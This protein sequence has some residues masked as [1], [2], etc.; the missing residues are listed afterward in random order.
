MNNKLNNKIFATMNPYYSEAFWNS[1]RGENANTKVL[2]DAMF[3][4]NST[5]LLPAKTAS[6]YS[7]ALKKENLFRQVGTVMSGPAGEAMFWMGDMDGLPQWTLENESIAAV[8][9]TLGPKERVLPI[10]W[11]LSH[12][13]NWS[14]STRPLS[15]WKAIWSGSSPMCSVRLRSTHSS[16]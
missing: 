2:E 12:L 14:S 13:W 8:N 6:R 15:I 11:R 1:M 7:A 16:T 9:D 5:Y 10:S 3:T 4:P